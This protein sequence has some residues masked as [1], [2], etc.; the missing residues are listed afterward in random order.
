MQV[1]H[2]EDGAAG[3][4][5][6]VEVAEAVLVG[7][8][9]EALPVAGELRVVVEGVAEGRADGDAARRHIHRGEARLGVVERLE[10][11]A[12]AR[13]AVAAVGREGERLAVGAPRGLEVGVAVVGHLPHP[14][15]LDIEKVEIGDAAFEAGEGNRLAV[16]A[17]RRVGERGHLVHTN[18]LDDLAALDIED[19]QLVVAL[20]ERHEG[21]A[22]AVWA[23]RPGARDEAEGVE[24]GVAVGLGELLHDAP[25]L[26][27]GDEQVDV[28]E[29]ALAQ[30][31]HVAPVG[32]EH[33]GDVDAPARA[34]ARDEHAPGVGGRRAPGGEGQVRRL[35]LARPLARE[36]IG[37]EAERVDDGG[38]RPDAPREAVD[39]GHGLVAVL[40]ADV[41]HEGLPVAVGEVAPVGGELPDRR[42]VVAEGGVAHPHRRVRVDAPD[43][44]VL[45]RALHQPQRLRAEGEARRVLLEGDVVLERVDEFVAEDVVGLG[46]GPRQ[47]H[48][49]ALL[50]AL[51][52]AARAL[53]DEAADGVRLLEVRV[54]GVEEDGLLVAERVQV[55][56]AVALVP[57]LGHPSGVADG[58][59]GLGVVVDLE[60]LGLERPEL[61]AVVLHLVAP[62]VLRLGGRRGGAES[63]GENEEAAGRA[64]HRG[65]GGGAERGESGHRGL[66]GR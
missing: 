43:R 61:E 54:V 29:V 20:D 56:A 26:D 42:E 34:A 4:F 47:R 8:E 21:E 40:A 45:R 13:R 66:R 28:E 51:G 64:Q 22:L 58:L 33:R 37:R 59:L 19:R 63:G 52:H 62:E 10:V 35:D 55:G 53:A 1:G 46:V 12:V 30:V 41:G 65:T 25:R 39:V 50:Q 9:Q 36:R 49:D 14:A 48:R 5:E 2:P 27:V 16:R 31:R 6:A 18:A 23:P 38:V 24:V 17:P 57:A 15:R 7:D 44:Q 32:R 60:V 11:G 3:E